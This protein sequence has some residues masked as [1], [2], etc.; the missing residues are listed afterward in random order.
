LMFFR[1][2]YA[3]AVPGEW[4]LGQWLERASR[5]AVAFAL[6]GSVAGWSKSQGGTVVGGP[7]GL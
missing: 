1:G 4:G 7:C 5:A 6:L 3:G 2:G